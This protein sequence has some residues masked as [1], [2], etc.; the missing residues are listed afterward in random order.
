MNAVPQL[1]RRRPLWPWVLG[2][3]LAPFVLVGAVAISVLTL[4]RDAAL[5]RRHVMTGTNAEWQTKIQLSVGWIA[6]GVVR[7]GLGFVHNKEMVD[8]QLALKAVKGASVGI[9]ERKTLPDATWSREALFADTDRAMVR[10]GWSRLVGVADKKD[11]VIV[12]GPSRYDSGD[13]IEICLAVVNGRELVVVSATVDAEGLAELVEKH[14][15][16]ELR[17]SLKLTKL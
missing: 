9:Y 2:I 11:T 17:R 1:N 12:Y 15:G 7:T 3:C 8:A 5:L 16:E 6:L 10:R 4:D 14:A 13:P